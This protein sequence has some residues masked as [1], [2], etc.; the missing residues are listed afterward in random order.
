MCVFVFKNGKAAMP[1]RRVSGFL[2]VFSCVP[3]SC[4]VILSIAIFQAR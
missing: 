3:I 4:G 1:F 2:S